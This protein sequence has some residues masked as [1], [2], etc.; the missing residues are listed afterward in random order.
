M[1]LLAQFRDILYSD[2]DMTR[3]FPKQK[4]LLAHYTNLGT[5]E[6]ILENEQLW[7]SNP[8]FMNDY[9]EVAHGVHFWLNSI[10]S[11]KPLFESLKADDRWSVFD[12]RLRENFDHFGETEINNLYVASFS[13]HKRKKDRD[14]LLSMWRGYGNDGKGAALIIDSSKIPFTNGVAPLILAPV[15]YLTDNKRSRKANEVLDKAASFIQKNDFKN[16]KL[17]NLADMLFR[18][19]WAASIFSKHVGF[20]EE[21]EW[22]LAYLSELD[23]GRIYEPMFSYHNDWNGIAP[24]LKL[25][26]SKKSVVFSNQL[27]LSDCIS[28]IILGPSSVSSPVHIR[29]FE[30]MLSM[31]GKPELLSKVTTSEIPY[32]SKS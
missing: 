22:R 26:L 11:H 24:K 10:R 25:D 31:I 29:A 1:D 6:S 28:Q 2:L 9:Q 27:E 23:K 8:L 12:Q 14:G 3:Q 4:P 30:R 15:E 16:E 13:K 18:R 19:I 32:R 20:K 17:Q 7:L 21:K 5:L